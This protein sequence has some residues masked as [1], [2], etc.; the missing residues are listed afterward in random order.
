MTETDGTL[1]AIWTTDEGSAPMESQES[2]QAVQ[3]GLAGD[4]Y[5]RGTGYYSPYDVCEVT[6]IAAEAL[7]TIEGQFG[8]DLGD[9]R[10]RRNLVTRGADLDALLSARF[11]IGE[12]VFEGTRPR[13]P[14]AHVAEVGGDADLS[15]ALGEDRG[16]ICADVVNPGE[17]AVGDG[18]EV[19]ESTEVDPD[20]IAAG[21]RER[22]E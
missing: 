19:L 15:T 20:D 18:L 14:C 1:T 2:I 13:P 11:R 22:Y 4:R 7:D 6:L 17:I 12:A 3:G 21:I 16:G 9:G 5:E 10:H 8:I